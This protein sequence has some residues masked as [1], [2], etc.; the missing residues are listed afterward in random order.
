VSRFFLLFAPAIA[1]QVLALAASFR[2]RRQQ[3]RSSATSAFQPS[4]SVLKPVHGLDPNTYQAFVSQARQD[5]P[6]FEILF[7]VSDPKDPVIAEIHRLRAQFPAVAIRLFVAATAAPNAKVGTL[8]ELAR[9]AH[10]PVWVVNDADI[11]VDPQYLSE[12]TAPLCDPSVGVVTCAYRAWAHSPATNWEALGIATDF[13]PSVFVAQM[14]GVRDFGLGAT[15]A[16]RAADLCAAGGFEAFAD[17]LADDYQLARRIAGLG[18]RT[19]LSTYVVETSL[20]EGTW[21]G[22][23]NHQLRWGRTIRTS[24]GAGYLGL[25]ITQAGLWLLIAICS[26]MWLPAGLLFVLRCASAWQS[27][28]ALGNKKGRQFFWLA[29]FWDLYAFG[30]WAASYIG[31]RVRWRDRTL[32]INRGGRLVR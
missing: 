23:W 31:N 26:H 8:M 22:V 28:T 15:L 20:D 11:K 9:H 12:V 21:S 17:Y 10:Y 16:F 3:N 25:P 7:G 5:Y 14:I 27:T 6:S 29:P 30:V 2:Y 24:K 4:I 18:K 19:L 13:M 1:Y 32:H